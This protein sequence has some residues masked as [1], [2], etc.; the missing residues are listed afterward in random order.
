MSPTVA[1]ESHKQKEVMWQR[2]HLCLAVALHQS[3]SVKHF[4]ILGPETGRIWWLKKVQHLQQK[5]RCQWTFLRGKNPG[6]FFHNLG[7]LLRPLESIPVL[8]E[9]VVPTE[10]Q[11]R[12][13]LADCISKARVITVQ[14]PQY[15][16]HALI[17][18][19]LDL[20]NL[21]VQEEAALA[22]NWIDDRPGGLRLQ[23]LALTTMAGP[24]MSKFQK[25]RTADV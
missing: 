13:I 8:R 20:G 22:T 24:V 19:S 16:Q 18:D 9:R 25:N 2:Y 10:W 6:G 1:T 3:L 4:L 21:S 11:V 5:Y 7:N 15:R 17:S 23:N 12:T 14:A